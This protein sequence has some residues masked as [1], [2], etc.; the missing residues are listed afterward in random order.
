[1]NSSNRSFV[2]EGN[3]LAW[4]L[5]LGLTLGA[6]L[7]LWYAPRSGAEFREW[8][9]RRAKSATDDAR[10]KIEAA[11]PADTIAQSLAE[12]K[13]AARRRRE[14]AAPSMR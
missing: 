9:S 4:G 13:E 7:V 2:A 12:G 5:V 10:A 14:G 1:M 11:V 3:W 6:A 8:A